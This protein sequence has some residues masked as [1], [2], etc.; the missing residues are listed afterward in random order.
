MVIIC[1]PH[2]GMLAMYQIQRDTFIL[3][4][5][6]YS[7]IRVVGLQRLWFYSQPCVLL[8]L[9]KTVFS[10]L[11]RICRFLPKHHGE[12]QHIEFLTLFIIF[13]LKF[14]QIKIY[15][16]QY[17]HFI[18]MDILKAQQKDAQGTPIMYRYPCLDFYYYAQSLDMFT[19][20]S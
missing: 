15:Y 16:I 17:S 10:T 1:W 5:F 18:Y 8:L 6:I 2:C 3:G 7:K 12:R 4:Q 20:C 19:I 11:A 13:F 9:H 14:S